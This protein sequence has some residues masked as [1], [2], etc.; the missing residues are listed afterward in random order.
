MGYRKCYGERLGCLVHLFKGG[1]PRVVALAAQANTPVFF[2]QSFFFWGYF[3]KRK[4]DIGVLISINSATDYRNHFPFIHFFFDEA[5]AKK[6]FPKRNAV[7]CAN[8]ARAVAFAKIDAKQQWVCANNVR[9]KSKFEQLIQ[10][11]L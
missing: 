9:D 11:I 8:A 6:K 10:Q 2:L 4:S 7:F 3:L 5:S 1:A